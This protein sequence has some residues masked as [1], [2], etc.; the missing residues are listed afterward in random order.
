M[1]YAGQTR[2]L[3]CKVA[4]LDVLTD[5]MREY[6]MQQGIPT[7]A[8]FDN[9]M[10]CKKFKD[11]LNSNEFNQIQTLETAGFQEFD[12]SLMFKI[13]KH[14]AFS[15]I[16]PDKP[17]RSRLWCSEP[18]PNEDSV[19]DNILRIVH[20]RNNLAH[21][22]NTSFLEN[23]FEKLFEIYL[24]IGRRAEQHLSINGHYFR[25]RIEKYKTCC[26]DKDMEDKMNK[27]TQENEDL[28]SKFNNEI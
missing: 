19:G 2:F 17:T 10:K 14:P 7:K 5:I 13:V 27:L 20:C 11:S 18:V 3:R 15:M 8:I 1:A 23:E 4:A 16:I 21:K 22:C 9:I 6:M 26:I 12:I 24:D 25:R 28:R